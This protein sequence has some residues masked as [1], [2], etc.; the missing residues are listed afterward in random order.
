MFRSLVCLIA[1]PVLCLAQAKTLPPDL[2][3]IP[4]DAAVV[5]SLK[6]PEI[7]NAPVLD[8]LKDHLAIDKYREMNRMIMGFEFD[9][10]ERVTWVMPTADT[11]VGMLFEIPGDVDSGI[12]IHRL[13]NPAPKEPKE[14]L[15]C[16][17]MAPA[18]KY[19]G[20]EYHTEPDEW[21]ALHFID[22]RTY[23]WGTVKSIRWLID[24][25]AKGIQP[26]AI[27]QSLLTNQDASVY[28]HVGK[29]T[30]PKVMKRLLP[31][32]DPKLGA[33]LQMESAYWSWKFHKQVDMKLNFVYTTVAE[34]E[35]AEKQLQD[36]LTTWG[37]EFEVELAKLEAER[38]PGEALSEN[39]EIELR[40][41]H[42]GKQWS[43]NLIPKR[44]ERSVQCQASNNHLSPFDN[45]LSFIGHALWPAGPMLFNPSE[46][47]GRDQQIATALENY[48]QKHGHYP[49]AAIYS[50]DGKPLLSWRVE[51]LPFLGEEAKKLYEQ[52]KKDEPWDS[53]HNKP[54]MKE[55][56]WVYSNSNQTK[57]RPR[58]TACYR[59]FVG[60]NGVFE[61]K[62]GISKSQISDPLA[63][64]LLVVRGGFSQTP[65]TKP[66]E[67]E[68]KKD[69]MKLPASDEPESFGI[70][71]NGTTR[72]LN[73]KDPKVFHAMLTRNGGEKIKIPE[74]AGK[75]DPRLQFIEGR[76][77]K[78]K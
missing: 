17:R 11:A 57:Y 18:T 55:M 37:K 51:L 49:P 12:L 9:E 29:S 40:S 69:Q 72:A 20:F 28:L 43:K 58:P 52:F 60:P 76:E 21:T 71:A 23:A 73:L 27:T 13:K 61:G 47:L 8:Y 77:E 26:N 42:S 74:P 3:V 7:W 78:K 2:A 22:D 24:H 54:L 66:E 62:T 56:P 31:E 70:F 38:K 36:R 39:R 44:T 19:R 15:L 48:Q 65:W 50:K 6:V 10:F 1:L 41:L 68:L 34:A 16:F 63:E 25:R 64:T 75:V 32:F 67:L 35:A 14:S 4:P 30:A 5:V 33:I 53:A 45:F 46:F 59:I